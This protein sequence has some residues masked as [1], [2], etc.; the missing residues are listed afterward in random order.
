[1][2]V[3]PSHLFVT[4]SAPKGDIIYIRFSFVLKKKHM[5]PLKEG[6]DKNRPPRFLLGLNTKIIEFER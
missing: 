6:E 3:H 4:W 2:E 1:M 5:Q